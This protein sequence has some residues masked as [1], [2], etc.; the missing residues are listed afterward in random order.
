MKSITHKIS[1]GFIG[2]LT[3]SLGAFIIFLFTSGIVQPIFNTE[4]KG[5]EGN[6]GFLYILMSMVFVATF[7]ANLGM[8][9]LMPK[10][11]TDSRSVSNENQILENIALNIVIFLM[12]TPAYLMS[13]YL[14]F[15]A[16]IFV[17]AIHIFLALQ[18][19][20]L[21]R[22]VSI[23]GIYTGIFGLFTSTALFLLLAQFIQN[24][25]TLFFASF[26]LIWTTFAI[27]YVFVEWVGKKYQKSV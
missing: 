14:E 20:I 23:I 2:G 16:L 9:A 22:D 10:T 6:S 8:I 18:S 11:K 19:T 5:S 24:P 25:V 15:N 13:S 4:I 26:P 3:G 17:M 1:A 12:M 7:G 27:V 21:L